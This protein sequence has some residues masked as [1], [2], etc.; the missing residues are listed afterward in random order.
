MEIRLLEHAAP[1]P[2]A[3]GH[4]HGLDIRAVHER[5]HGAGQALFIELDPARVLGAGLLV[6]G[7]P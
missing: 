2:D 7:P 3:P 1:T 5:D 6:E 4:E